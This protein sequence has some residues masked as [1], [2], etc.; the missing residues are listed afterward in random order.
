VDGDRKVDTD[1]EADVDTDVAFVRFQGTVRSSRGH[2]PGVFALADGLARDGVLT[3]EQ[4]RFWQTGNDW[5]DAN[6]PSP[7]TVDP[8]VYDHEL[9]PGAVAWFKSTAEELITH[10]DGYLDLLA[11]HGVECHKVSSTD[12]GKIVY[13]DEYQIVVVPH[14]QPRTAFTD[15]APP[16]A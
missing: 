6:Y 14:I 4:R 3:E 15:A 1:V 13:E 16:P 5:Y 8:R 9:Y 12:P 7:S 11:A 2:F 10:M